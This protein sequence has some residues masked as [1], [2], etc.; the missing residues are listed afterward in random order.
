MA[1]TLLAW[2]QTEW[3]TCS[4]HVPVVVR[5]S[6]Q[7]NIMASTLLSSKHLST[8]NPSLY[9]H[10]KPHERFLPCISTSP[11]TESKHFRHPSPTTK[12]KHCRHPS[13]CWRQPVVPEKCAPTIPLPRNA[14]NTTCM[15]TKLHWL[16]TRLCVCIIPSPMAQCLPSCNY[17]P[18][19]FHSILDRSQ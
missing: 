11:P 15:L 10:I 3:H 7:A 9:F 18:L 8:S 13:A 5:F 14:C 4:R 1:S 2:L 17:C 16:T 12:S 19:N 6:K